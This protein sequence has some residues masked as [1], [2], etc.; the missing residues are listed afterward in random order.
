MIDSLIVNALDIRCARDSPRHR[1][2]KLQY[3]IHI[4]C[5]LLLD[6]GRSRFDVLVHPHLLQNQLLPLFS[7]FDNVSL[8]RLQS[9]AFLSL[10][11]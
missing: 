3:A 5:S 1:S 9:L 10:P 4:S 6:L 2:F 7:P 8:L 11:L